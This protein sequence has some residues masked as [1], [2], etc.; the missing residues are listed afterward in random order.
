MR[1]KYFLKM[2]GFLV[3]SI[4]LGVVMSCNH[5][6]HDVTNTEKSLDGI[7]LIQDDTYQIYLHFLNNQVFYVYNDSGIFKKQI[8]GGYSGTTVHFGT[9][10][11][12]TATTITSSAVIFSDGKVIQ[13]LT[14]LA[15]IEKIKTAKWA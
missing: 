13:I 9:N 2:T 5:H 4:M 1:T 12:I 3:L 11:P 15:L 6:N 7:V 8:T 10:P 14:D